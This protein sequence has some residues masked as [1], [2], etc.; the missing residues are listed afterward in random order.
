[1]PIEGV[2]GV[3]AVCALAIVI[4]FDVIGWLLP[5]RTLR[6]GAGLFNLLGR[7][8]VV[9]AI[10]IVLANRLPTFPLAIPVSPSAAF[11]VIGA[12]FVIL[13]LL[14]LMVHL[15]IVIFLFVANDVFG[16][17]LGTETDQSP[18]RQV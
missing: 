3:I 5:L 16:A 17:N 15:I 14:G 10:A 4:V 11:A 12:S 2:Y 7:S 9:V 1:M 6:S 8:S 18:T 13:M